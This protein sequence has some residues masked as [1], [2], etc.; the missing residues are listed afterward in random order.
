MSFEEKL[1]EEFE[2]TVR[3]IHGKLDMKMLET[4]N[5]IHPEYPRYG[6]LYYNPKYDLAFK[7]ASAGKAYNLQKE[8][9]G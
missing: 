9:L 3:D 8:D 6:H 5:K 7:L 2:K 1:D 4:W